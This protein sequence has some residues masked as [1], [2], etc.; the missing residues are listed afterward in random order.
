MGLIS[1]ISLL[2][3]SRFA[4]DDD[5]AARG[6]VT[7]LTIWEGKGGRGLSIKYVTRVC[8]YVYVHIHAYTD[9]HIQGSF[10]AAFFVLY[11]VRQPQ[12]VTVKINSYQDFLAL[13]VRQIVDRVYV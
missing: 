3:P 13:K 5:S 2:R 9:T 6:G 1:R 11:D 10:I 4:D 7:L 12:E 8:L